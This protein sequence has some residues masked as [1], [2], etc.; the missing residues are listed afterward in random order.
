MPCSHLEPSTWTRLD[1]PQ[2]LVN[3]SEL[4]KALASILDKSSQNLETDL[5]GPP[6]LFFF[7]ND[8]SNF[9][10]QGLRYILGFT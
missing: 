4:R 9:L 7:F 3:V 1:A 10:I 2:I 5:L 6:S 8:R